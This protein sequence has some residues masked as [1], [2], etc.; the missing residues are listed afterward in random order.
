M[1]GPTKALL[2]YPCPFGRPA[3]L[4]VAHMTE[5]DSMHCSALRT[6]CRPQDSASPK[7]AV[8]EG[9]VIVPVWN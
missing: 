3:I 5:N 4:T 2:W 1:K 8:Q 9:P 7:N 6:E